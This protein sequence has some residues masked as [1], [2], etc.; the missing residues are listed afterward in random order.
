MEYTP[1]STTIID[2]LITILTTASDATPRT[3]RNALT[4]PYMNFLKE[5]SQVDGETR[6]PVCVVTC[7][8]EDFEVADNQRVVGTYNI[9]IF[10]TEARRQFRADLLRQLAHET[11]RIIVRN[12]PPDCKI[13]HVSNIRY[14]AGVTTDKLEPVGRAVIRLQF[15]YKEQR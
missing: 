5:A 3:G 2:R 7:V 8:S 1:K 15:K 14:G 6:F 4:Y 13:V 11:R 9:D 10:Y 12:P